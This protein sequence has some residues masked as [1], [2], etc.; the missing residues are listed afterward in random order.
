MRNL[1]C[2]EVPGA[3]GSGER[4]FIGLDIGSIS[5]KGVALKEDGSLVAKVYLFTAGRP[6][7]AVQRVLTGL[8]ESLK[9]A[10]VAAV[11]V[12]GSG[13][14]LAGHAVGADLAIDE[15]TAQARG[16][17][18]GSE[19]ADSVIEIGGQD[20]KFIRLGEDSTV[21]DFEMNRVCA[22]GTGSFIQEQAARLGVDL[23]NDY[24]RLALSSANPL[25]F[26]SRCTVFMGSDL[27]HY[28]QQGVGLPDLLMGVSRAVVE[29]YLDRVAQG[30]SLGRRVVLQGGVAKNRSVVEAFRARLPEATVSVHPH[31]GESGAI[32]VALLA[33]D[34]Y[35]LHPDGES[36]FKGFDIA[37][38]YE[39]DTFTCTGCE[40]RCE[41]S[42]FR[43]QADRFQFGDLCGRYSEAIGDLEPGHDLTPDTASLLEE[44]AAAGDPATLLGIPRTMLFREFYPFWK[45]FFAELAIPTRVSGP[46][47]S[48][49]MGQA[50]SRLPA[51]TCLPVKL[52]FGHV[53]ALEKEGVRTI[54][55]P[56]RSRL[57]DGLNCPYVQHGAAM[58]QAN[59]ETLRI[60]S[61]PLVPDL[62]DK[63]KERLL[64][65]A[66][67]EF[68]R[69]PEQ[70]RGAYLKASRAL[71]FSGK[72]AATKPEGPGRGRDLSLSCSASPTMSATVSSTWPWR[73]SWPR[74]DS[75]WSRATSWICPEIRR[76]RRVTTASPGSSAGGC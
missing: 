9:E 70:V 24:A 22:A 17:G 58:V 57:A 39:T 41:V 8:A 42:V 59:F 65:E 20:A 19:Q 1:E 61:L 76:C 10:K 34:R 44:E 6:L 30:R 62:P 66:A 27:V 69:P 25:P 33:R 7:A 23:K 48:E 18:Y 51:E 36:S 73:P 74:R 60:V 32:G 54:F 53:A 35:R 12:T 26:A 13:R 40:N 38:T 64:G 4:V 31:P 2:R 63:E 21:A 15:I 71:S 68:D 43:F 47:G 46:S 52:L 16:A 55:I 14:K 49:V 28:I 11:G 75:T 3:V 37:T 45:T 50:L 5:T 72:T 56:S 67:R 29:N